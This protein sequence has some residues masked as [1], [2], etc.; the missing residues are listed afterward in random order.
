MATID[1][2]APSVL[3]YEGG[4]DQVWIADRSLM[5]QE[6]VSAA[7]QWSVHRTETATLTEQD[8]DLAELRALLV[9]ECDDSADAHG[10]EEFWGT[11]DD[12]QEWRVRL[13]GEE[14]K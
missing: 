10:L 5:P 14:C 11:T 4:T 12:G 13:Q 8:G 1:S 2:K 3:A 9:V 7:I 6:V